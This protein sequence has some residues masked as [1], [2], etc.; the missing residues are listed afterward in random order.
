MFNSSS[1]EEDK[2]RDKM[3]FLVTNC[4][5]FLKLL[6]AVY[7]KLETVMTIFLLM[8]SLMG[9]MTVWYRKKSME[10]KLLIELQR[11]S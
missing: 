3:Y 8:C 5:K 2:S 11:N 1:G 10:H 9:G 6:D 7:G 4:R